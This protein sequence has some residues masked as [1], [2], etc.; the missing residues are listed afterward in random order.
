MFREKFFLKRG[1]GRNFFVLMHE[2]NR[3]GKIKEI[4]TSKNA[5]LPANTQSYTLISMLFLLKSVLPGP[6][7]AL[8]MFLLAP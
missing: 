6:H 4:A 7:V 5:P 2:K 3:L 1:N 8:L